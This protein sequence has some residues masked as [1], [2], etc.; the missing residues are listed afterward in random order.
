MT[1]VKL[2]NGWIINQNIEEI[3]TWLKE[4]VTDENWDFVGTFSGTFHFKF[5]EHAILFRLKFGI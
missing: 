3:S 2:P 4:Y 5:E 1:K